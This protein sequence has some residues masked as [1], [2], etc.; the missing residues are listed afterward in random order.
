M[1]SIPRIPATALEYDLAR[2][3]YAVGLVLVAV[4]SLLVAAILWTFRPA[5]IIALP[6]AAL[7]LILAG[8]FVSFL[9]ILLLKN[10]I[11]R[12]DRSGILDKRLTRKP[13]P[14]H[15]VQGLLLVGQ[16]YPIPPSR[17]LIPILAAGIKIEVG[18]RRA[19]GIALA[20]WAFLSGPRWGL[21]AWDD[22]IVGLYGLADSRLESRDGMAS[23]TI[24]HGTGFL[25]SRSESLI[26]KQGCGQGENYG[27]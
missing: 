11:L 14:W 17:P 27:S 13:V 21:L 24:S 7:L 15:K 9:R 3:F 4:F 10:P 25:Q 5:P 6:F 8:A 19:A 2:S 12:L 23:Q 1:R 20:P 22:L 26:P 16:L 18:N